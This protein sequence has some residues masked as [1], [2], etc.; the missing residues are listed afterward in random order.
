MSSD[1]G[2]LTMLGTKLVCG[3]YRNVGGR[4]RATA[5]FEPA[6][7]VALARATEE[8]LAMLPA[9]ERRSLLGMIRSE[10]FCGRIV[11]QSRLATILAGGA[12][13]W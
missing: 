8:L 3:L 9:Q 4:L 2:E 12:V 7:K 11:A 10:S 5:P 1:T 6:Q 13:G